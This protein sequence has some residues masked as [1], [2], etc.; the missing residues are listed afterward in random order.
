MHETIQWIS[1]TTRLSQRRAK[2]YQQFARANGLAR[3]G[4]G[5]FK[6][7]RAGELL[8]D[9]SNVSSHVNEVIIINP[10]PRE[11]AAGRNPHPP[12]EM[13]RM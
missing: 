12:G 2:E 13:K 1:P 6:R 5:V 8:F 11:Y 10:H 9:G 4:L 7:T 3:A